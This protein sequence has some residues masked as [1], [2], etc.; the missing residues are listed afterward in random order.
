MVGHFHTHTHYSILDGAMTVDQLIQKAC[1]GKIDAIAITEHGNIFSA[2]EFFFKASEAGIKPIIGCEI[3]IAPGKLTEKNQDEKNFHATLIVKNEEGYKNLCILLKI[4]NMEGFYRKPRIDIKTLIEYKEGLIMLSGCLNGIIP[5][6]IIEGKIDEARKKAEEFKKIFGRD[7][8]L[9]IMRGEPADPNRKEDIQTWETQKKVVSYLLEFSKELDIPCVATADCHYATPDGYEI[10]DML[11]CI[12]YGEKIKSENRFRY[13]IKGLYVKSKEEMIEIFKDIPQSI[14][15]HED[16]IKS[17]SFEFKKPDHLRIPKPP[18]FGDPD[19]TLRKKAYEG[20][21]RRLKEKR[22]K[23]EEFDEKIYYEQLENELDVISKKNF[24]G[25][26]L[27]VDDFISWAK[28][29]GIMVGP[30]RGSAAGSLVSYSL[31]IT[32][33]DPIKYGLIFERF[34]NPERE[35]A[36]DIDVDFCKER[37]D[38]VIEYVKRKYGQDNV[39]HIITF[40]TFGARLAIR[41]VGRIL[42]EPLE[43]VS[44]LAELVP[45]EPSRK[46]TLD[47]AYAEIPEFKNKIDSNPRF[48]MIFEK[49]KKLE[50]L[51]RH[52]GSHASGFLI[53]DKPITEYTSIAR[54][55]DEFVTQ[56]DMESLEKIGL[57]K[58]DF[59]GLDTLT[60]IDRTFKMIKENH[61]KELSF[62]NIPLDDK[63]TY[64][65]LKKGDVFGVFQF[66]SAGMRELLMKLEPENISELIAAVALYRPGPIQSGMVN[67][68]IERKK[69]LKPTEYIHPDLEG[70]LKETYGNFLYQEQIMFAANILAG[71]SMGEADILR[72]AMGKKKAE[73]MEKVRERFLKGCEQKGIPKEKAEE[74]FEIMEKFSGYAFNKSHSAAYAFL[75]YVTAYLKAN[76]PLEYMASLL[77]SEMNNLEKL[78]KYIEELLRLGFKIL[79]PSITKSKSEFSVEGNAIR[80]GLGGIKGLGEAAVKAI[81][82]M[83][84][85][86]KITSFEG[87][88]K[89]AHRFKINKKVIETLV[90]AGAFDEFISREKALN[91]LE[92]LLSQRTSLFD[93]GNKQR[94]YEIEKMEIETIGVLLS[95]SEIKHQ[96]ESISYGIFPIEFKDIAE[97][98]GRVK[99]IIQTPSGSILTCEVSYDP[100]E[101]YEI[102]LIRKNGKE[103]KEGKIYVFVG[104]KV[105][106]KMISFLFFEPSEMSLLIKIQSL[107]YLSKIREILRNQPDGNLEVLLEVGKNVVRYKRKISVLPRFKDELWENGAIL[108]AIPSIQERK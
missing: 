47:E 76:F 75:A 38:E 99:K 89:N 12:A 3:Y 24:S 86:V 107:S 106:R 54:A 7:F 1:E 35:K 15:S 31:G 66:E 88:I 98:I 29:K 34:L 56:F 81:E 101:N 78:S 52:I 53:S 97:I 70:I 62:N 57:V 5:R 95:K 74:I 104:K 103:I 82:E 23:G 85:R 77:T 10:Q 80:F 83:R 14:E 64:E 22:D 69:G 44:E 90:K 19:E 65:M 92:A 60:V 36:P 67:D 39:A 59:L 27:I 105:Q 58:F 93:N 102:L 28:S 18:E 20:L 40:G 13:K 108:F 61:G 73:L 42:D 11:V 84:Q 6:L 49:A 41:D 25:Y 45:Q 91:L 4:A 94:Q 16:I 87:F 37:R 2:V 96:I 50:G 68:F 100:R 33:I 46:W 71:F 9:E 21:K 63:K 55:K 48:R 17:V 26:F 79:P 51:I 30:G 8:Y 43:S 32:E 72:E